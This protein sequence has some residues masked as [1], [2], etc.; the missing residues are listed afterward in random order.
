MTRMKIWPSPKVVV[1]GGGTGTSTILRGLKNHTDD[2]TAIITVMDDGGS[3]GRLRKDLDIIAPGDIRNCLVALSNS[4]DELD[5][6]LEYRF[7]DGELSGHSFGNIFIA[8]MNAIHNDFSKAILE[9]GKVLKITGKV[10]P[11]TLTNANLVAQLENGSIINGESEIPIQSSLQ[12]S[13]IKKVFTSPS[14]IEML[15]EAKQA[16]ESADIVIL[17]P[18]SLFT[19]IIP[20]LLVNDMVETLVSCNAK[21]VYVC[22][23]MDQ[24]GETSNFTIRDHYDAI[25]NHAQ[26]G[27]IDYVIVNKGV[28]DPDLLRIYAATNS[29]AIKYNKEDIKYLEDKDVKTI[30]LPIVKV[31]RGVIRHDAD[32]LAEIIFRDILMED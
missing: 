7:T 4:S 5:K 29:H 9:T 27:M 26:Q 11:I 6:L 15:P 19:S 30:S 21:I 24:E 14:S 10:L 25:I 16:I 3:T 13:R 31:N 22:N 8:A 20:N 1:I 23:I 28:I 12:K 18:G 2:L 17:G 32:K